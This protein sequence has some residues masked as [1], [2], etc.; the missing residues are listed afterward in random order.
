MGFPA[1]NPCSTLKPF[2]LNQSSVGI[3]WRSLKVGFRSSRSRLLVSNSVTD[4]QTS[5]VERGLLR[6]WPLRVPFMSP[7]LPTVSFELLT[8]GTIL[9]EPR[10]NFLRVGTSRSLFLS[11]RRAFCFMYSVENPAFRKKLSPLEVAQH[12][13][14]ST[15][16]GAQILGASDKYICQYSEESQNFWGSR[17]E[18]MLGN[19]FVAEKGMQPPSKE[20][21]PQNFLSDV[22]IVLVQAI[23][24]NQQLIGT[25]IEWFQKVFKSP[26]WN[27]GF[28]RD[29]GRSDYV[30][31]VKN[32]RWEYS[33]RPVY[34]WGNVGSKQQSTAGWL[35]AF[36]AQCNIFEGASGEVALTVGGGL[37]QLPGLTETFENAALIGVHYDGIFY[38]FVPWKGVVTWEISPWGYWFVTAENETHLV[39]LEATTKDPE[40][41]FV[42]QQQRLALLQLA[43]ILVMVF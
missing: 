8:A 24:V 2:R 23:L 34:G 21:P 9:M 1:L 20:V 25:L 32:A 16:V 27:Q 15:G 36:P 14:R 5:T 12:G 33:T 18:L 37:R 22:Q 19:T 43:K 35:A 13:P 39:E 40:Q 17:H 10:G 28:I 29:D 30:K 42:L 3:H 26:L 38:E 6:V 41:H 31:T 11:G 4:R 7:L